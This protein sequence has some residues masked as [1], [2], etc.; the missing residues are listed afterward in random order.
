MAKEVAVGK[1][2]KISQ[3][4]EYV[5]LAVLGA[6]LFLGV[7]ISLVKHYIDKISFNAEVIGKYEQ[8]IVAYSNAIRDIGVCQKPKGTIY[9][10]DEIKK[11]DPSSVEVSSISGTLRG[12]IIEDLAANEALNSVPKEDNSDCTDEAG[13]AY[14]YSELIKKYNDSTTSEDRAKASKLI[15]SCSA[16][17]VIP[18]ALPAYR[19]EEAL[20]SSLNK[21]FIMSGWEPDM[22]SPGGEAEAVTFGTNLHNLSVRLSVEAS[23]PVT[24]KVLNNIERSIREFD[25]KRASIEWGSDNTLV[26]NAQATAYYMTPSTIEETTASIKPNKGK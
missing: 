17:R 10:E 5:L 20:L 23:T 15:Q 21:I 25:I 1:R 22:L 13:N 8:S 26:I 12:N 9:S 24:I 3:A 11:C 7:A 16:L 18:D 14:T 6:S 2:A 4:Q 19:N